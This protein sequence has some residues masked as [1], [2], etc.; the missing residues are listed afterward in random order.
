MKRLFLLFFSALLCIA[1]SAHDFEVDGIYYYIISSSDLT[2]S[3]TYQGSNYDSY[4]NE[5]TG[6]VVI[7]EKVTYDS[8]EYSVTS[9]G[10]EAFRGCDG[11]TT[12]TIPNSVTSIISHA[13]DGCSGMTAVHITDLSAWCKIEFGDWSSNPTSYAHHLYLNGDEIIN[14]VIPD[15]VTCIGN[16]AFSGCSGLTSVTIPNSVTFIGFQAFY[17]TGWYNDHSDGILYLDSWLIGYKGDKPTGTLEI[18]E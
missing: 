12:V 10:Y 15:D 1:V 18:K 6:S 9:I 3:V 11:L 16:S 13:F 14:L 8:K 4:S 5:Y 7:P 17:G 2:V